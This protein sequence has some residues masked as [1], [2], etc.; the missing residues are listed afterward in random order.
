MTL[1]TLCNIFLE[2]KRGSQY[3]PP[4]YLTSCAEWVS[5]LA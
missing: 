4:T 3:V 2:G 1:A 5:F